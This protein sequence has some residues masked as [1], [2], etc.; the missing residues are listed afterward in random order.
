MTKKIAILAE[1]L[2]EDM[3]LWYPYH[4]MREA[5]FEQPNLHAMFFGYIALFSTHKPGAHPA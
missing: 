2:Y 3:E 1:N 4:R 5:G